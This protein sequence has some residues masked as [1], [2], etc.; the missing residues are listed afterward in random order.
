M[1]EV[2]LAGVLGDGDLDRSRARSSSSSCAERVRPADPRGR[3]HGARRQAGDADDGRPPDHDL[4]GGPVPDLL[5]T[6]ACPPSPPSSSRSA[7][8][9]SASSDDWTK[10]SRR[11]SLGL[12]GAGSSSGSGA[13]TVVV[14]FVVLA[15]SRP[16]TTD[17]YLPLLDVDLPL[18]WAWYVL[19]FFI[20]AGAANG[21]NLTDGI[22][23]LAAGTTTI[24]LLTYTA[25]SLVAALA[26]ICAVGRADQSRPRPRHPR[27][28][29]HRGLDRVPLVQRL[30]RAG[31]HGRH[32][33]DGPRRRA[34]GV[35]DHDEDRGAAP[36][37]R[38]HLRDRGALGDRPGRRASSGTAGACSSWRRSTT[39][40]R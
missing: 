4:D 17:V 1:V 3:P 6:D 36:P 9:R 20:I 18:G 16:L 32:G 14:G 39:T 19:L 30:P 28:Q 34:R 2:L 33:L 25:M 12:P 26:S 27:R 29:P 23:G 40:S 22:D 38:R 35:R 24:A 37:D 21:V 5:A 7:A 8:P 31:L 15:D 11:R 10:V 13:I